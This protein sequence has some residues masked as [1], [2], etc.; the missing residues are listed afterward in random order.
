MSAA[1]GTMAWRRLADT[2]QAAMGTSLRETLGVGDLVL[3][4]CGHA[5][6]VRLIDVQREVELLVTLLVGPDAARGIAER[7]LGEPIDDPELAAE[8]V[9]ELT[10]IAMGAVKES[11]VLDGFNLTSGLPY[12]TTADE[13]AEI[14]AARVVGQRVALECTSFEVV[15]FVGLKWRGTSRV[16]VAHLREGMVLARDLLGP[17]GVLLLRAG[18]RMTAS[19]IERLSRHEGEVL[20]EVC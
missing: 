18:A 1:T 7:M 15:F 19:M 10:N 5:F 6:S 17:K 14:E 2:L 3:F 12:P 4:P 11:F 9:S 8:F 16:A 13:L 20:A